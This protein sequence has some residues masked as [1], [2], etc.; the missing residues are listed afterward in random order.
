[1]N[2]NVLFEGMGV[3]EQVHNYGCD[4]DGYESSD[5]PMYNGIWNCELHRLMRGKK[6]VWVMLAIR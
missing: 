6:I 5:E 3:D 2:P 1:M 4:D